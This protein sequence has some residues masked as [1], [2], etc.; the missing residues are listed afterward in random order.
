M[1]ENQKRIP[2]SELVSLVTKF[3]QNKI[4]PFDAALTAET[5]AFFEEEIW[6]AFQNLMRGQE[7]VALAV[8]GFSY[9]HFC[10]QG[11][12]GVTALIHSDWLLKNPV[13][14]IPALTRLDWDELYQQTLY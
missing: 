5:I 13:M 4:S 6:Q 1:I 14:A 7:P 8:A 3:Y 10:Q 2:V 9:Q 12:D 11:C